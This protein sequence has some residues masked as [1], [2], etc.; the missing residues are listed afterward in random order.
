MIHVFCDIAEFRTKILHRV[1]DSQ[2]L[3]VLLIEQL[4][5]VWD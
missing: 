4:F 3:Q 5:I 2:L 1:P